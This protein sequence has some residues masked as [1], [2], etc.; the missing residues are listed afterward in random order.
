VKF[1]PRGG[2]VFIRTSDQAVNRLRIEIIDN[3]IG[4]APAALAKIFLP[5]EQVAI[6]GDQR[7]GGLGLGLAIARA[8]VDLHD[9][10]ISAQSGGVNLGATFIVEFPEATFP[11]SGLATTAPPSASG[12][13]ASGRA[14]LRPLRLLL[15]EDHLP[16]LQVLSSLLTRQGHHVVAVGTIAEA[17]AAANAQAFNLV[18]SDL[19]LPDGTGNQLMEKLR[20]VHGLKGIALSG[21]GMDEDLKRSREAGFVTHLVKPVQMEELRRAIVQWS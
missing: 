19:G 20:F 14:A 10:Q 9:G 12:I 18:I 6:A 13:S 3:G 2:R 8:I 11:P 17:L 16:T 1:T 15:V 7:F 4:I 5:F 21:Y